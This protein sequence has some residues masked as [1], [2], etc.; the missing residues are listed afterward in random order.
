MIGSPPRGLA[1]SM[2]EAAWTPPPID[3]PCT[4]SEQDARARQARLTKPPGSLG[5]LEELAIRL[6]A[7][8]RRSLPRV[9]HPRV[10]LLAAD[11]GITR[12]HAVSPYPRSVTAQM[13]ANIVGGGAA[14]S[15][16]ARRLGAALEVIDVGVDAE[17]EPS[18]T[19]AAGVSLVHAKVR[20]GSRDFTAE[21]ALTLAELHQALEVG[22]DAAR[23]AHEHG[24]TV[25]ALGEMGIGNTTAAAAVAC[26]LTDTAPEDMVGPGTGADATMMR[27]KVDVVRRGLERHAP[28]QPLEIL[29]TVGGLELAALAGLVLGAAS[30]RI[31]VIGDGFIATA[32]TAAAIAVAPAAAGY[33][34]ASHRSAEPG[35]ARLLA[36]LGMR[37][38]LDLDMR[39]G[40]GSG[41]LLALPLLA[42]AVATHGGMAS[43]EDAGVADRAAPPRAEP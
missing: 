18:P 30:R 15:C 4:R 34:I 12:T 27:T 28:T 41:A 6:A 38:L 9:E 24:S 43:F 8:Q 5:R 3:E 42:A 20:R 22:M 39:L 11:H 31:A 1:R 40:E 37:P 7:I 2:A 17:L 23:R 19:P 10:V 33:V 16:L 35:H 29:R 32:A 25:V 21:P 36:R 14:S 26:A 13:V